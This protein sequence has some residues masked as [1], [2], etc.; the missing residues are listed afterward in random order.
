M[1]PVKTCQVEKWT[2][3]DKNLS[4]DGSNVFCQACSKPVS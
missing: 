4:V 3:L 2:K 1:P